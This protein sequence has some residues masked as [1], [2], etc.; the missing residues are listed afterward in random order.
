MNELEQAFVSLQQQAEEERLRRQQMQNQ[1]TQMSSFSEDKDLNGMEFQLDVDK[2]IEKINHL[3]SGHVRI[4][5]EDG[6]VR[7]QEPDDD[8]LKI[9]SEYGVKQIMNIVQFYINKNTLLSCYDE[10]TIKQKMLG[11]GIEISDL[12]FNCYEYFFYH[13]TPEELYNLLRPVAVNI[14]DKELYWKCVVW[15]R[16]ELQTRFRY[17]PMIIRE[18]VDAVHSTYLR[19]LNGEERE[20]IRR[21]M[22]THLSQN[23]TPSAGMLSAEK[24]F[25]LFNPKTW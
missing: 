7:W 15:S 16:E 20:S 12:I 13:P 2:E 11:F 25:K 5:D 19:A 4:M 24:R 8:R 3:L 22:H 18:L 21:N 14:T 17:Y 9:F 10:D 23:V 6:N 1:L